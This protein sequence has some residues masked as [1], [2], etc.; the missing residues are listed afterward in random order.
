MMSWEV[1]GLAQVVEVAQALVLE[2][3]YIDAGLVA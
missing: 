2:R 3:G 1:F